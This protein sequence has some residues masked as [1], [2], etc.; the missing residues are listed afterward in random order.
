VKQRFALKPKPRSL[1][2][3]TFSK[4]M[5]CL[6]Q[7]SELEDLK[8]VPRS[9]ITNGRRSCFQAGSRFGFLLL[10]CDST[11]RSKKILTSPTTQRLLLCS[12]C[13]VLESITTPH[14]LASQGNSIWVRQ[15]LIRS[16]FLPHKKWIDQT[17]SYTV[18]YY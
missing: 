17:C 7:A 16:Q 2:I 10:K 9:T 18:L 3:N 5:F 12:T 4:V 11:Q 13:F 8:E 15:V 6:R 1:S 14:F